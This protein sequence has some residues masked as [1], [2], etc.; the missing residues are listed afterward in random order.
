MIYKIENNSDSI[1]RSVE[2]V[3]KRKCIIKKNKS[4]EFQATNF[5]KFEK[6]KVSEKDLLCFAES[7]FSQIL[8][9]EKMERK[10]FIKLDTN[11]LFLVDDSILLYINETDLFSLSMDDKDKNILINSTFDKTLTSFI[12]PE[13]N[14][15]REIPCK[16]PANV[17]IYSL[18]LFLQSLLQNEIKTPI[19]YFVLRC[20]KNRIFLYV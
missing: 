19:Y 17:A 10:C 7:L 20:I 5:E 1:L 15:V 6:Q 8:F 2:H 18:G 4:I 16:V 9:L 11:Y 13:V 12:A 3:L 14:E